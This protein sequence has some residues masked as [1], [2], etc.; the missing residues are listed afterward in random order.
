[1]VKNLIPFLGREEVTEVKEVTVLPNKTRQLV[2]T[3]N[4]YR[5]PGIYK[6]KI[7]LKYGRED[8]TLDKELNFVF[9]P[10]KYLVSLAIITMLIIFISKRRNRRRLLKAARIIE[11]VS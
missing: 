1:M 3:S 6:A 2:L 9:I 4:K 8:K 7:A 10:W 5:W 11:G